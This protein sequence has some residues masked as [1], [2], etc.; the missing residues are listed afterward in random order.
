MNKKSIKT[1]KWEIKFKKSFVK[2][3]D[4]D[5]FFAKKYL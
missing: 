5:K 3:R 4:I 2:N 1:K